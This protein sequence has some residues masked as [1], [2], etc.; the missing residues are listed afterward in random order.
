LDIRLCEIYDLLC[1]S[2]ILLDISFTSQGGP[3]LCLIVDIMVWLLSPHLY[4]VNKVS[5]PDFNLVTANI[6]NL[7]ET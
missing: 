3:L 6:L 1:Y 5:E 7:S 2:I 4:K